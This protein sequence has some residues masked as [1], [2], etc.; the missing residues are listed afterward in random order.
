MHE[1]ENALYWTELSSRSR[2]SNRDLVVY[3]DRPSKITGAACTHLELR[4]YGTPSVRK[5][6]IERI[7]DLM[8]INPRLLFQRHVKLVDFD[9]EELKQRQ[10]RAAIRHDIAFYRGKETNAFT[11]KYRASIPRRVSSLVQRQCRGRVQQVKNVYPHHVKRLE[12]ISIDVLNL[13][14]RLSWPL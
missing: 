5:Q 2:R 11:D 3:E 13:P 6:G 10:V 7:R 8:E 14:D 4:F 9:P 12:S 1:E